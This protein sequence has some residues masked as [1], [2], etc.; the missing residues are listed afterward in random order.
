MMEEKYIHT[1][2][3]HNLKSP[4]EIVPEIMKLVNP[5]SVIDIGCGVG[6]FLHVFKQHGADDVLGVDGSWVNRELLKTHLSESEF[7]ETDLEKPFNTHKKF[8]LVVSLEVAEH[9]SP[10]SADIFISNLV[11]AGQLIL[12]SAAIPGQGGQH[13]INEQFLTYWEAKFKV[14][15]YEVHDILRPVFWDNPNINWWY[16]QNMVMVAP[17]GF[18]FPGNPIYGTLRN[19]VHYDLFKLVES[20]RS[21]FEK[22]Q[23]GRMKSSKY[24]ALLL[25][26]VIGEKNYRSIVRLIK[27]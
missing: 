1:E 17:K 23:S 24:A 21:D 10:D 13:H 5:K 19:I 26:S 14:H 8:D 9:I 12:F 3:I 25:K 6:T 15:G 18:V 22:L 20:Q 4:N 16:K 11:N 2:H 27:R 7:L